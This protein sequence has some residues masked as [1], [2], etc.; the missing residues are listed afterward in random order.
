MRLMRLTAFEPVRR[1]FHSSIHAWGGK[2]YAQADDGDAAVLLGTCAELLFDLLQ[3]ERRER[4]GEGDDLDQVLA[5][6]A[7]KIGVAS[8]RLHAEVLGGRLERSDGKGEL[9]AEVFAPCTQS[10]QVSQKSTASSCE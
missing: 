2:L 6:G 8:E 9:E 5:E 10:W 4:V 3:I 7:V 1:R